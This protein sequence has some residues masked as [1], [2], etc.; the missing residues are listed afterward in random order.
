MNTQTHNKPKE[1]SSDTVSVLAIRSIVDK[2]TLKLNN[3]KA[4]RAKWEEQRWTDAEIQE[5]DKAIQILAEILS[6]LNRAL[7]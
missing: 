3:F 5:V 6:D 2:H 4:S 7:A 1:I